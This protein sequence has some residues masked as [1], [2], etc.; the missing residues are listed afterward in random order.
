VKL[1]NLDQEAF[2]VV[3]AIDQNNMRPHAVRVARLLLDRKNHFIISAAKTKTHDVVVATLSLKNIVLG[4]PIK[5]VQFRWGPNNKPGVTSD[6]PIVHGNGYH[7]THYN[8]YTLAPKLHPHLAVIDGFQ[9][10]EGNGPISGTPVDHRI[11]ITSLDWLAA[12]RVGVALMGIDL[13]KVAYLNFCATAGMGETDL[14]KIEILGEKVANHVRKYRLADN[15]DQQLEWM[16][17]LPA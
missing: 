8:L 12:D 1:V 3:H 7:G 2:E 5:S 13:A 11:A 15:I 17:P 4:A 10:M 6:K 16:K 9:G 14:T